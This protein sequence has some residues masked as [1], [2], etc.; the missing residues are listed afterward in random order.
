VFV[1]NRAP[2]Q[3]F[4][5]GKM[6]VTATCTV[7]GA[8]A[9]AD[10]TVT[11]PVYEIKAEFGSATESLKLTDIT[12]PHDLSI[13][14]T[15][16]EDGAQITDKAKIEALNYSVSVSP[17]GIDNFRARLKGGSIFILKIKETDGIRVTKMTAVP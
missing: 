8:S 16:W 13:V 12:K 9:A 2:S 11:E 10:Y 4:S 15:V 3:G 6:T 14:F 5:G 17:D 1:P 7:N